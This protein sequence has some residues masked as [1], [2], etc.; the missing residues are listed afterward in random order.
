MKPIPCATALTPLPG[1]IWRRRLPAY[2]NAFWNWSTSTWKTTS[3]RSEGIRYWGHNWWP[4]CAIHSES[5]CRCASYLKPPRWPNYRLKS[6]GCSSTTQ[7]DH[8]ENQGLGVELVSFARP[9]GAGGSA[10]ALPPAAQ[11]R[12]GPLGSVS[13]LV[14]RHSLWRCSSRVARFLSATQPNPRAAY[15]NRLR[16]TQSCGAGHG[17]TD[18]V[19]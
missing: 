8:R 16:H 10:S 6:D 3:S 7:S 1:R 12:P 11:R 2:W 19:S 9:G 18:A 13:A 15:G 5:R 4:G 17:Q 14:G